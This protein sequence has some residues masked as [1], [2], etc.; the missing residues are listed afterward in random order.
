VSSHWNVGVAKAIITPSEPMWL[1]GWAVRTEPAR[2]TLTDLFAKALAIEGA[3]GSRFVLIAVDLIAISRDIAGNVAN[4]VKRRYGLPRERLMFCASHTHCGPEIR[5]D[6]VPFFG[7]PPEFAA[8]IGP[9]VDRLTAQLVNLVGAAL[10]NLRPARLFI[11]QSLAPFAHNR[12]GAELVNHDVPILEVTELDG[13]RRAVVFGYA[14]HNTSM[15]PDDGRYSADFAEFAQA[16]L[17]EG[18]GAVAMFIAGAG[19]DQDPEPRGTL[20][21]ASRHGKTL[22]SAIQT[23]LELPGTE[24]TGSLCVAYDET[25]LD[26]QLLPPRIDLQAQLSSDDTPTRAKAAYL[27]ARLDHGASFAAN[28]PCPL[29]VA[30]FGDG[31]L[32][33]A[34]G[35]EPVVDYAHELKRRYALAGRVVWVAGYANDM[36]GY[37]P[38]AAVLKRGGYEGTRSVLWSALPAPFAEN[39]EQRVFDGIDR[40]VKQ[41]Y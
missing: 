36:F 39:T 14:C 33:I 27:L 16:A 10:V 34:I 9:Y 23:C 4:D 30:R 17:E 5:P 20:E 25:P 8:K 40:L 21:F 15:P 37:V 28:Y 13:T 41:S 3:N 24:L 31:L 12:R 38:S 1:A 7:I 26:F 18:G 6:K 2:G 19:A 11:R 32:L 22:A 29:Q 35:G